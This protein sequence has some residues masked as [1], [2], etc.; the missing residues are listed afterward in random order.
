MLDDYDKQRLDVLK[1]ISP[2]I[3]WNQLSQWNRVGVIRHNLGKNLSEKIGIKLL[4][5]D[6]EK[7]FIVPVSLDLK[8]KDKGV[9]FN[10]QTVYIKM[11]PYDEI[12]LDANN[13]CIGWQC[14]GLC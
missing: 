12:K 13:K 10:Q 8:S 11:G 3:D 9:V 2:F 4:D 14:R 1:E 7:C 5:V 6:G